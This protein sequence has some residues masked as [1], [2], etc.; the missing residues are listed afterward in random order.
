[1]DQS[2]KILKAL[3]DETRL[4]IIKY[5]ANKER[6]VCEIVP[7]VKRSQSTVSIQL[8]KLESL[9]VVESRREGKK[10][11]YRLANEKVRSILKILEDKRN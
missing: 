7:Y 5:L 1:M 10:V 11:F 3:C 2:L 9:E 6:C 8:A 4:K